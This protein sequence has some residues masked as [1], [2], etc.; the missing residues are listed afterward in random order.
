MTVGTATKAGCG[1]FHGTGETGTATGTT[2]GA[3]TRG[4]GVGLGGGLHGGG[5]FAD[6]GDK[7]ADETVASKLSG[8][9]GAK[10]RHG[11]HHWEGE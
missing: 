8:G 9:G 10:H 1:G 5:C 11:V 6:I 3:L 7:V 4:C 2:V